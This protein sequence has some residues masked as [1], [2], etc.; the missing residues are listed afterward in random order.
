VEVIIAR[1]GYTVP[2]G[3]RHRAIRGRY[4]LD[5]VSVCLRAGAF[6]FPIIRITIKAPNAEASATPGPILAPI[7]RWSPSLKNHCYSGEESPIDLKHLR[8]REPT[9]VFPGRK[10]D[11]PATNHLADMG[12]DIR[13]EY[14]IGGCARV[15]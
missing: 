1:N 8:N 5:I 14:V 9:P 4:D 3:S 12:E 7:L 6:R 10:R 11:R 15:E 2:T 13:S